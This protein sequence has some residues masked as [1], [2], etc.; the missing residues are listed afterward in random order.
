[1]S[2]AIQ[3]T[4][5]GPRAVES[6]TAEL[7]D[8]ERRLLSLKREHQSEKSRLPLLISQ[9]DTEA[10]AKCRKLIIAAAAKMAEYSETVDGLRGAITLAEQRDVAASHAAALRA[11]EKRLNA[12]TRT[13]TALDEATKL[14]GKA[15][16][17][18]R[19]AVQESDAELRLCGMTADRYALE[20]KVVGIAALALF[21]ETGHVFGEARTLDSDYQVRQA[22]KDS[23][24]LA[25][26]EYCAV[27]LRRA[28]Q[29]LSPLP[30]RVAQHD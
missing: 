22:G 23:Q 15:L 6:L 13:A 18:H 12:V 1:M 9:G 7:Q 11:I 16:L 10:L 26:K 14:Y 3:N 19:L 29:S 20:L 30:P 5:P 21:I 2:S 25:A 24:K 17:D 27:T 4:T 28:Q 8:Y